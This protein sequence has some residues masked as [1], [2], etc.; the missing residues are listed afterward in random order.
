MG[1]SNDQER[2]RENNRLGDRTETE[3]SPQADRPGGKVP[4]T[5]SVLSPPVMPSSAG[6]TVEA[7][8]VPDSLSPLMLVLEAA[9]VAASLLSPLGCNPPLVAMVAAANAA[10]SEVGGGTVTVLGLGRGA[11]PSG[12]KEDERSFLLRRS[13]EAS[14]S[15]KESTEA[16]L[17]L[18]SV[19][20]IPGREEGSTP[21]IAAAV[22]AAAAEGVG[23]LTPFD[24]A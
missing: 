11:E 3:S 24:A 1:I 6:V 22:A 21:G 16:L 8:E 23:D 19:G 18:L 13:E 7:A 5:S 10:D 14:S 4:W 17:G 15:V 9:G 12:T 2:R 20:M